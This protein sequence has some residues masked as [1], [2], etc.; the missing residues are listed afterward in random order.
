HP[1]PVH[2]K[3]KAIRNEL[4]FMLE[5]TNLEEL[6]MGIKSGDTFLRY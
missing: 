1:C 6:A 4:A 2:D 5:N 3:F